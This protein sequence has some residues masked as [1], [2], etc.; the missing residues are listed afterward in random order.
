MLHVL[1]PENPHR[2]MSRR[3]S[4]PVL[5][6]ATSFGSDETTVEIRVAP[7]RITRRLASSWMKLP[8]PQSGIK[9]VRTADSTDAGSS[10]D[11][12]DDT[13]SAF[14]ELSDDECLWKSHIPPDEEQPSSD[15]KTTS[16]Y[17][18]VLSLKRFMTLGA[19]HRQTGV[20]FWECGQALMKE[21]HY[22][23]AF[24]SLGVAASVFAEKDGKDHES[25]AQCL[26]ALALAAMNCGKLH[27]A[28][29]AAEM[30]CRIRYHKLGPTHVDTIEA[31]STLGHVYL[32]LNQDKQ[33]LKHLSATF[34]VQRAVFGRGHASVF[35]SARQLAD[36]CLRLKQPKRAERYYSHAI[37]SCRELKLHG[38]A[39]QLEE[40]LKRLGLSEV[41]ERG[42]LHVLGQE[43]DLE[44]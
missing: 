16:E 8:Q 18:A 20:A 23:R 36:L 13:A 10:G 40:E 38:V 6:D 11:D 35:L 33:A 41:P 15:E 21:G 26:N 9:S 39:K 43:D 14:S 44:A 22:V 25:L 12:E 29:H 7:A 17:W 34:K 32:H 19:G 1:D 28:E 30:A 37:R 3:G 4:G 27:Y 31:Y 2:R 5:V 42:E 24:H